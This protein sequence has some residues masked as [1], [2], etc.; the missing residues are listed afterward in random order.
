MENPIG[1]TELYLKEYIQHI[2]WI[3]LSL[4]I[5]SLI[6]DFVARFAGGLSFYW[7][8]HFNAGDHVIIDGEAAVIISIGMRETVFEI[9]TSEK[10]MK[11]RY[12][13]ND[14]IRSLKL[15]KVV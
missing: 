9:K 12:V 13:P 3:G 5:W 15:E 7:D 14:K 2:I 1:I 6:K 4:L 11:W 8:K 10:G